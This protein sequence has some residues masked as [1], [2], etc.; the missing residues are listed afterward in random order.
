MSSQKLLQESPPPAPPIYGT[1]IQNAATGRIRGFDGDFTVVPAGWLELGLALAYTDDRYT[2]FETEDA[3]G[4]PVDVSSTPFIL[5][6]RI[7]YSARSTVHLPVGSANGDLSITAVFSRQSTETFVA[8]PAQ[9]PWDQIPAYDNLD[10]NIT[11]RDVLGHTGLQASLFGT[12]L[13]KNVYAEGHLTAYETLGIAS[14]YPA[15]PR[16]FGAGLTYEF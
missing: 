7:K 11:W 15:I 10:A 1:L 16:M 5:T 13:T 14:G 6:P 3:T 12:N 2:R 4:H 9:G 8:L